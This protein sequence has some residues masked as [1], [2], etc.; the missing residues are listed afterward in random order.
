M[1]RNPLYLVRVR[2][3]IIIYLRYLGLHRQPFVRP[4]PERMGAQSVGRACILQVSPRR[5]CLNPADC[6]DSIREKQDGKHQQKNSII[7]TSV[8]S[9]V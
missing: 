9:Q 4:G 8:V 5:R 7:I 2:R 6:V 1:K 3:E